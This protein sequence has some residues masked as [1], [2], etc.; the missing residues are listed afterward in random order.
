MSDK[1]LALGSVRQGNQ[2][3]PAL[4]IVVLSEDT[5]RKTP[6]IEGCAQ[7]TDMPGVR[8]ARAQAYENIP[9]RPQWRLLW[10][11]RK[12]FWL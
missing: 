10:L 9:I 7:S 8:L 1:N 12:E 3:Q 4:Y 5:R 11:Q 6:K 2:S